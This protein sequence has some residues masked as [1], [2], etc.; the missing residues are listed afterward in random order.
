MK[1]KLQFR[2]IKGRLLAGFSVVIGLTFVIGMINYIGMRAMTQEIETVLNQEQKLLVLDNQLAQN[3]SVRTN[4]LQ[5]YVITNDP[6]YIEEFEAGI[7]ESIA[8]ENEALAASNSETLE[9]LIS[10]KIDWGIRT[11]ELV[12][13]VNEGEAESAARLM[14]EEV[15]PLSMDLVEGFNELAAERQAAMTAAL[16]GLQQANVSLSRMNLITSTVVIIVT[17]TVALLVSTHITAPL[18]K[19]TERMKQLAAG[20]LTHEAFRTSVQDETGQLMS[21]ADEMSRSLTET[22]SHITRVAEKTSNHSQQLALSAEGVQSETEQIAATMQELSSGTETQAST[23]SELA[24]KMDSFV[25]EIGIVYQN[26]AETVNRSEE[27]LLLSEEG[28][29]SMTSSSNQMNQIYTLVRNS[30]Q[31]MEDLSE[32]ANQITKLV[33]IVQEISDQT[34]LLALN[35]AIEAARAG[36]QGKG[37]AVV[38]DEVRKLAEQVSDSVKDITGF[39]ATIQKESAIVSQSLSESFVQVEEGSASIEETEGTFQQ[40]DQAVQEMNNQLNGILDKLGTISDTGKAM[41]GAID[42]IA[43]V[44]EESAAGVEQTAAS[45]QQITETT[46]TVSASASELASLSE[47]LNQTV[48]TF[49]FFKNNE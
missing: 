33:T 48:Q 49:N 20:D 16:Q 13:L 28:R 6:L 32:Q 26:G 9:N 22:L 35:A 24:S 41:N 42:D 45:S 34:N 18:K 40:I 14:Q 23:V 27:V 31:R 29:A 30:V 2:S 1:R 7:E 21:A 11:D 4:L 17:I 12:H 15:Q 46:Q 38:A 44:S 39:V 3:M 8:L 37:F 19:V 36:E 25:Q 47:E 10:K 43:A 5:G